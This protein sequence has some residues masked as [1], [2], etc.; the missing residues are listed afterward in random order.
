MIR[1]SDP[2]ARRLPDNA[3]EI[4]LLWDFYGLAR[5]PQRLRQ[6]VDTNYWR[7]L[8]TVFLKDANFIDTARL[9][10]DIR[11]YEHEHLT[12]KGIRLGFAGDVALSQSLIKGIVATQLQSLTHDTVRE[13]TARWVIEHPMA[14]VVSRGTGKRARL[15]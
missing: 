2:D 10:S 7:S 4:K 8:T 15:P 11:A 9:M 12:P 13:E 5:G 6:V 1:T 3:G 14:E